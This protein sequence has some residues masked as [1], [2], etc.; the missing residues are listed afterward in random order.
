MWFRE[1]LFHSLQIVGFP[2]IKLRPTQD[3]LYYRFP[4]KRQT[5]DLFKHLHTY[6]NNVGTLYTGPSFCSFFFKKEHYILC[7]Q[8]TRRRRCL[9]LQFT[10]S[11]NTSLPIRIWPTNCLLY[12]KAMTHHWRPCHCNR[13]FSPWTLYLFLILF[14]IFIVLPI[15][16]FFKD[17]STY[18]KKKTITKDS[19]LSLLFL[20]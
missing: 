2:Y 19:Y 14:I 15:Y 9:C 18:L 20:T 16:Y 12:Q 10:R 5:N 13:I 8:F 11:L 1:R 6:T 7:L 4:G 3:R 17:I